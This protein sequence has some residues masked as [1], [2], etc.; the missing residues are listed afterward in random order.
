MDILVRLTVPNF[1][2]KFYSQ[3]AAHVA[4]GTP[5]EVMADALCAYAGLLSSQ[6]AQERER[7]LPDSPEDSDTLSN[8]KC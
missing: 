4:G 1:V 5:E 3:A 6:V 8:K 7:A 2:Y